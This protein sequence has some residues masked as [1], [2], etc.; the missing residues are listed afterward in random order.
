MI[1]YNVHGLVHLSEKVKVFGALDNI[2]CF[3]YE[4]YLGELKR[5]VR[6]PAS[7]LAQVIRRLSEKQNEAQDEARDTPIFQQQHHAGPVPVMMSTT[8]IQFKVLYLTDC[9]LKITEG[10]NCVQIGKSIALVQNFISS[11]GQ[12]YIV[13]KQFRSIKSYFKY[14]LNSK[15]LG[16]VKVKNS[17]DLFGW[18]KP[19]EA[20]KS[21]QPRGKCMT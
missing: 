10:N 3:P 17:K 2:S 7:P 11:Q 19:S 13:F 5:L 15:L 8:I 9:T 1:T 21:Q 4:S 20:K 6:K 14:P 16:F 18:R 12:N